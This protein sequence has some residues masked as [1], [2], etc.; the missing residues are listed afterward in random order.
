LL[1]FFSEKKNVVFFLSF[2]IFKKQMKRV[3]IDDDGDLVSKMSKCDN[4]TA[5]DI[6]QEV[7][8]LI[9]YFCGEFAFVGKYVCREWYDVYTTFKDLIMPQKYRKERVGVFPVSFFKWFE[10][11][12]DMCC[13]SVDFYKYAAYCANTELFIH[14]Q[15]VVNELCD[16]VEQLLHMRDAYGMAA[17]GG[18]LDF[19]KTIKSSRNMSE[20]QD[21]INRFFTHQMMSGIVPAH[22]NKWESHCDDHVCKNAATGGHVNVLEWL[23]SE[24]TRIT[25]SEI[26]YAAAIK[27]H[28]NVIKWLES[29]TT[30]S[31]MFIRE[32]A[33]P[34]AARNGRLNIIEWFYSE[35][36][37][38]VKKSHAVCAARCGHLELLKWMRKNG[39][40]IGAECGIAAAGAGSLNVL[41]WLL[42]KGTINPQSAF[43]C[44][45]SHEQIGAVEL[46]YKYAFSEGI[47]IRNT[48][49]YNYVSILIRRTKSKEIIQWFE[50]NTILKKQ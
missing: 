19:M 11:A 15:K 6:P 20:E 39:I 3:H 42:K 13:S 23:R 35:D 28:L 37:N 36:K 30:N 7:L 40:D 16:R 31:G 33:A 5:Q 49:E 50:N 44:A 24:N 21:V 25:A 10:K 34:V 38:S 46:L 18:Q 47:D 2:F 32:I 12:H 48:S 4:C 45:V 22:F 43:C 29:L 26:C 41:A 9:L 14:L 27:G 8:V 1:N 17:L